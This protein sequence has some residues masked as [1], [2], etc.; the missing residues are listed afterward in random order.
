MNREE[1]KRKNLSD[2]KALKAFQ[3]ILG[4]I[5]AANIGSLILIILSL[6]YKGPNKGISGVIVVFIISIVLTVYF[7][8]KYKRLRKE[9]FTRFKEAE[10]ERERIL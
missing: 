7:L 10:K 3:N 8:Q 9:V 6:L 2:L 5:F 4:F 1:W